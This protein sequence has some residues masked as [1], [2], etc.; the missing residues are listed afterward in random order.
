MR[1]R[2][3]AGIESWKGRVRGRGIK[4]VGFA[5]KAY[6]ES[7][8]AEEIILAQIAEKKAKFV[9]ANLALPSRH[10]LGKINDMKAKLIEGKCK[11]CTEESAGG[12]GEGDT[13]ESA[14][15][16]AEGGDRD[17]R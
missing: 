14:G 5:F 12:R 11:Q 2:G 8:G 1:R 7:D 9:K 10:E 4:N 16:S 13:G 3:E 15:D 17:R 6:L